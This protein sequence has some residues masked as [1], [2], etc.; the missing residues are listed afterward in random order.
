MLISEADLKIMIAKVDAAKKKSRKARTKARI[1]NEQRFWIDGV[2]PG[3]NELLKAVKSY[4][5]YQKGGRT[6]RL[7]KYSEWKR[8]W[9]V[10]IVVAIKNAKI[11][12]ANGKVSLFLSFVEPNRRR[13]KPNVIIGAMDLIPDALQVAGIL[14]GDGWRDIDNIQIGPWKVDK[15]RPGCEVAIWPKD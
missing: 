8:N 5:R 9:L 3:K 6:V 13:D 2:L 12:P 1:G 7:D 14:K 11:K 15:R 4:K 10:T